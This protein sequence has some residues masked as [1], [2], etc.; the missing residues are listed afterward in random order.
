MMDEKGG[1]CPLE[2]AVYKRRPILNKPLQFSVIYRLRQRQT[3]AMA[4]IRKA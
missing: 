2:L 4:A 3:G 1:L